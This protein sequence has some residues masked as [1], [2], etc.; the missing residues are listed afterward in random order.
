MGD[1]MQIPQSCCHR[2]IALA[3][4]ALVLASCG[5]GRGEFAPACPVAVEVPPLM[6]L[7]RYR[8]TS[9]DLRELVIR[10]QVVDV[11]GSCEPG[12]NANSVVAVARIVV[13]AV[14]GPAMQGDS[15]QLPAFIAITDSGTIYDKTMFWLPITFDSNI[16][17]VQVTSNDVRM[18]I[19]V[20]PQ[21]SAAAYGIIGG[22]QLSP[23][24]IANWRRNNPR[25]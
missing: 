4:C 5:P 19:P 16:D 10:A 20:T 18:V 15:V 12:D 17:T 25:R 21:K 14:R 24:E 11:Q 3:F 13:N 7:A 1:L 8:G 22:F 9:S 6:Q 2:I 23:E